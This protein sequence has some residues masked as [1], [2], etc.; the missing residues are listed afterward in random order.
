MELPV[1]LDAFGQDAYFL[2]SFAHGALGRGFA[3]FDTAAGTVDFSS[4]EAT[5]FADQQNFIAA[6]DETEGRPLAG[7]PVFPKR[8]HPRVRAGWR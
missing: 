4:A 2:G 6:P 5:L 1:F 8:V 7:L 3:G